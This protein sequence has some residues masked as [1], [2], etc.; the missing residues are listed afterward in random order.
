M[1]SSIITHKKIFSHR[2]LLFMSLIIIVTSII[3][4]QAIIIG[5]EPKGQ[6]RIEME[7]EIIN[8][9]GSAEFTGRILVTNDVR[10]G[11]VKVNNAEV[12]AIGKDGDVLAINEIG[13]VIDASDHF[14]LQSVESA[15]KIQIR[16]T[17]VNDTND[18]NVDVQGYN[19]TRNY[20]L[21]P[22]QESPSEYLYQE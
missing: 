1:E 10:R 13:N 4:I 8:K 19:I 18:D 12:R 7:G 14:Q 17:S 20:V 5:V 2:R 6:P 15:D 3:A 9:T 21:V 11:S 22:Y 16:F